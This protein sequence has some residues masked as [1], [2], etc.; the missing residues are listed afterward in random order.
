MDFLLD[1]GHK[2]S[3]EILIYLY[4]DEIIIKATVYRINSFQISLHKEHL[5][6]KVWDDGK[7]TFILSKNCKI[8]PT[9]QSTGNGNWWYSID[10]LLNL[11]PMYDKISGKYSILESI[12]H[13]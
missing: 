3:T 1:L 12:D 4:T 9:N 7:R 2:H 5:H 8:F 11:T 10:C 6:L 13:C